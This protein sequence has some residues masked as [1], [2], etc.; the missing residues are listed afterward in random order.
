MEGNHI[1]YR[2]LFEYNLV[3]VGRK[4]KLIDPWDILTDEPIKDRYDTK[5]ILIYVN[6]VS[7]SVMMAWSVVSCLSLCPVWHFRR[8]GSLYWWQTQSKKIK[9]KRL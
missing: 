9:N 3:S 4:K 5:P 1:G 7:V 6:Y 2:K 8:L